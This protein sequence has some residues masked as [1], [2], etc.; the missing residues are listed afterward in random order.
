MEVLHTSDYKALM[1]FLRARRSEL[2]LSQPTVGDAAGVT[3]A[4]ISQCELGQQKPSDE[5]LLRWAAALGVE[6]RIHR[7]PTEYLAVAIEEV[8]P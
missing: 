4:H 3:R 6:L 8:C 2:G 1:S 5:V 7:P